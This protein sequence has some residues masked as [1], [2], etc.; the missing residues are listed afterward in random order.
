MS[1]YYSEKIFAIDKL[2]LTWTKQTNFAPPPPKK[3]TK[4]ETFKFPT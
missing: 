3:K 1:Q 4:V 2:Y